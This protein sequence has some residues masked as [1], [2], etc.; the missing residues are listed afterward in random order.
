[1]FLVAQFQEMS[2]KGRKST[3]FKTSDSEQIFT[4]PGK[5]KSNLLSKVLPNVV[6]WL[7]LVPL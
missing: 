1:M 7:I 4:Q 3:R 6:Q 2:K 5:V